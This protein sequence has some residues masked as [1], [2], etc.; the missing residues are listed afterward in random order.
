MSRRRQEFVKKYGL[1]RMNE[2]PRDGF[3]NHGEND[4]DELT[5][6]VSS[7]ETGEGHTSASGHKR[8]IDEDRDESVTKV[9]RN[10]TG[11]GRDGH[12]DQEMREEATE[13]HKEIDDYKKA[14]LEESFDWD[15]H[16]RMS[17]AD[18]HDEEFQPK[19]NDDLTGHELDGNEVLKARLNEIEGLA[20]MGVWDVAPRE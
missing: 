14:N 5:P 18:A 10:G 13:D 9:Q 17:W 1:K 16:P 20:S 15:Q 7:M 6:R 19:V 3:M 8:C 12:E 4:S 2:E 11:R